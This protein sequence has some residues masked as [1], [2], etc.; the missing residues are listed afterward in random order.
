[1]LKISWV[2]LLSIP[3]ALLS[4]AAQLPAV[5]ASLILPT[6]N[7]HIYRGENAKF[8]MYVDR[9]FE[10]KTSRPWTA[11]KYGFVRNLRRTEDGIIG[12]RFHE[13]IDI[14]PLKRDKSNRPLDEIRAIAS[15]VVAYVNNTSARSNYG[16]YIV[17]EHNWDSGPLCSLYAHLS[18][19]NVKVGQRINQGQKIGIMGYT[20]SGLNRARSH[21]HLE[22][23]LLLST[24]FDSWHNK[25][26]K[27]S[28]NY[29]GNH[30]GLNLSGIDIGSFYIAQNND[31]TLTI[32]RFVKS[33]SV[34]YKITLPQR[35][36]TKNAHRLGRLHL[37][38]QVFLSLYL[39]VNAKSPPLKSVQS[40]NAFLNMNIILKEL[41]AA[42]AI[43][44]HSAKLA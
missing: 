37:P 26:F 24:N 2:K 11:G 23:N 17:I 27:G 38:L 41:L 40:E 16:K 43:E 28:K 36:I 32:P 31:K 15:G 6:D 13:G 39:Q 7:D 35:A 12:T 9:S 22:L 8:Y 10:G 21:L 18:E 25:H 1:M 5:P 14:S 20:G 4:L 3:F 29:H 34:Y 44:L 30:N 33:M 19:T 42:Q